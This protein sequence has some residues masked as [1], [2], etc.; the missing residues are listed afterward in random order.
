MP[1]PHSKVPANQQGPYYVDTDC[2]DCDRCRNIAP[3]HFA[4]DETTGLSYVTKQPQTGEERS[5]VEEAMESCPMEC[6]GNEGSENN[7]PA[8]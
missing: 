4:F 2:I 7:A 5:L 6:I 1:N 8:S 3:D